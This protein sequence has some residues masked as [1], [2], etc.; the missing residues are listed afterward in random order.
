[1]EQLELSLAALFFIEYIK[2]YIYIELDYLYLAN[3][4]KSDTL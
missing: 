2:N 1:M 3:I 4:F